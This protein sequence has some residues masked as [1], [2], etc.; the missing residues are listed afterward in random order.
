MTYQVGIAAMRPTM[1][2]M[3][4]FAPKN[5]LAATGPG[6]GGTKMCMTEKAP[7]AGRP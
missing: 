3:P 5:S 2:T 4:T 6:C 1:I 7:A